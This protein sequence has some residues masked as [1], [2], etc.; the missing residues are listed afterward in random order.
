MGGLVHNWG[1]VVTGIASPAAPTTTRSSALA[2]AARAID[3]RSPALGETLTSA[4][5]TRRSRSGPVLDRVARNHAA[6][7]GRVGCP[8]ELSYS[9][10]QELSLSIHPSAAPNRGSCL[11]LAAVFSQATGADGWHRA[12]WSQA[13]A[14][15]DVIRPFPVLGLKHSS[16]NGEIK[17]VKRLVNAAI[18]PSLAWSTWVLD[19]VQSL[20]PF[21]AFALVDRTFRGAGGNRTPPRMC[22]SYLVKDYPPWPRY[23]F[24]CPSVTA[25]YL[26]WPVFDALFTPRPPF[27]RPRKRPEIGIAEA[28]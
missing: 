2:V 13:N 22:A 23:V 8:D 16:L 28:N 17:I 21:R 26:E 25:I 6:H 7:R 20:R 15:L 19:G 18:R 11:M 9:A 5:H 10:E 12:C 3:G 1:P 4:P 27:F 14:M 24:A